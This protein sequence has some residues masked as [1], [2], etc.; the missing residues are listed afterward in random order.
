MRCAERRKI[1]TGSTGTTGLCRQGGPASEAFTA[2]TDIT[3]SLITHHSSLI[4]PEIS[5]RDHRAQSTQSSRKESKSRSSTGITGS[6]GLSSEA[7]CRHHCHHRITHHSSLQRFPTDSTEFGQGEGTWIWVA[8]ITHCR[9]LRR[10]HTERRGRSPRGARGLSEEEAEFPRSTLTPS[11]ASLTS[12][13]PAQAR[14][15]SD[16]RGWIPA[17]AGMTG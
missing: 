5:H 1:S 3:A 9:H 10:C 2:I 14:G 7:S 4:T 11:R 13:T 17:C 6:T 16:Y 15:P 12:V 8:S